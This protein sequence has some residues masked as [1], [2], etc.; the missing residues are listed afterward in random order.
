MFKANQ[1]K[2]FIS[3]QEQKKPKQKNKQKTG[4]NSIEVVVGTMLFIVLFCA[5]SDLIILSNRYSVLSDTG[6]ELA[7]TI[8]VQGGALPN[9]KPAG[10]PANYYNLITLR[11]MTQQNMQAAGFKDDQWAAGIIYRNH[12][13]KDNTGAI[14]GATTTGGAVNGGKDQEQIFLAYDDTKKRT[15]ALDEFNATGGTGIKVDYLK[16]FAIWIEADYD[17]PFLS[18]I[19]PELHTSMR[20]TMPGTS[21]WKYDYDNWAGEK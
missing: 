12:Y 18:T 6:K 11:K 13:E 3:T 9:S 20:V 21:E 5:V 10:Y 8:S 14:V 19:F 2:S 7:R 17:W 4:V 16:D 1:L 15:V